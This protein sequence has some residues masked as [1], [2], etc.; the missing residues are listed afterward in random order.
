LLEEIRQHRRTSF[1]T[2][3]A[4]LV[5][6]AWPGLLDE[7]PRAQ[8]VAAP[9]RQEVIDPITHVDPFAKS[10]AQRRYDEVYSRLKFE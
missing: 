1:P 5:A 3:T 9:P 8:S 7:E 10:E 2:I 4:E 6:K